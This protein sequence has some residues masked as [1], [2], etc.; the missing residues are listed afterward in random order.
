MDLAG[1]SELDVSFLKE[2]NYGKIAVIIWKVPAYAQMNVPSPLGCL[3][4]Y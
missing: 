2:T 4:C 3:Y 1:K